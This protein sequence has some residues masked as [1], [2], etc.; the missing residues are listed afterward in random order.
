MKLSHP[1]GRTMRSPIAEA[2]SWVADLGPAERARLI[3]L[4]QAAPANPPH[5]ELRAAL[6]RRVISEDAHFY[7][8]VL[9]QDDL[10]QAVAQRWAR[11]YR[12]EVAPECVAITAGC[13]Q[14]YCAAIAAVAAPGDTVIL[15]APYYFNHVMR[16]N[17]AGIQVR[18]LGLTGDMTPDPAGLE[19]LMDDTV[20]A[21]VLV[22]PNNPTGAEYSPEVLRR[23]YDAAKSRGIA[24]IL[25][26]TYLDFRQNTGPPHDLFSQNDWEDTFIH[27]YSFS[28]SYRMTGHR[29][30]TLTAGP[31]VLALVETYLDCETICAN[32]VGQMAA[33]YG[34][35]EL[36][37]DIAAQRQEMLD[38]N[39][40]LRALVADWPGWTLLSSGAFF[41]YVRHP[42]DEDARYIA[43]ALARKA[44]VLALP[45]SMFAP[46]DTELA[47]STMR[48]AFANVDENAL[49]EVSDRI[50]GFT[51]RNLAGN[52]A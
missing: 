23:F 10:R 29:V 6:A 44:G 38:R 4:S 13:N 42:Y 31:K 47:R 3:D 5:P 22:S 43:K 1:L 30:G 41:A 15:T 39:S 17:Y 19:T 49:H 7:G 33:L 20:R 2:R 18:Y 24:L 45:G 36:D 32:R 52:I 8:A 26:E 25:D 48:I 46:A 37:A 50:I 28:K 21:I 9:G 14:A 51:H 27:L 34:L 40:T 11:I 35:A 12:A 16:L